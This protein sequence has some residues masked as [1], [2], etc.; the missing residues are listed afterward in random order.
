MKLRQLTSEIALFE[1]REQIGNLLAE[2]ISDYLSLIVA[3][4]KNDKPVNLDQLAEF[5][6]GL[7]VIGNSEH[8]ES[9]TKADIGINPNDFKELFNTLSSI[10]K[11]GKDLPKLTAEV[12][13]ALKSITPSMFKKTREELAILEKGTKAEKEQQ[14]RKIQSFATKVNQLF[15][16]LKHGVVQFK[17]K[18]VT[19]AV[20]DEFA[21]IG[22]AP[23]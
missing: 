8:R 19:A 5:I 15:Y 13:T 6:S 22:G 9:I 11:N 20:G 18:T 1:L 14:I 3:M 4:L 23:A 16:K 2:S 12:F 10:T 21:N 7:K 17:D